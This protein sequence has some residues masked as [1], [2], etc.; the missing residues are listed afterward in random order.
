L[1]LLNIVILLRGGILAAVIVL[2]ANCTS[3]KHQPSLN[4][5]A[6]ARAAAMTGTETL[7]QQAARTGDLA[8]LRSRLREGVSPDARDPQGH[9][10]LLEAA[11]A[12]QTEATRLLLA[13]G[14]GVNVASPDG[15]TPLIQAAI[16][17]R[18]EVVQILVKAGADLNRRSRG[19]GTALEAAERLGHDDVAAILRQ[20][21]ARTFGRS[22]GDVVCVR[23]W[24]GDG[25]CGTVVSICKNKYR[26]RITK[27]MGCLDGCDPKLQCS[28]GKRVGGSNGLRPGDRVTVP[29]WCITQ[30]DVKP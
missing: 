6:Q 8:L 28:A 14:A 27:I 20:A 12:G 13:S 21:G 29:S 22:V 19:D 25:Y 2:L 9:T 26:I 3:A 10:A 16:S 17:G 15:R 23:P 1:P 18:T 11:T 7:L 5:Q 4:S 24:S 30:T